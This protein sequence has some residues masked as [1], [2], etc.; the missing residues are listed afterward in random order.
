M[1][2]CYCLNQCCALCNNVTVT[3]GNK[4]WKTSKCSLGVCFLS[5]RWQLLS[6]VTVQ[7]TMLVLFRHVS[8][9]PFR[10]HERCSDFE[11]VHLTAWNFLQSAHGLM[12]SLLFEPPIRRAT[13]QNKE[14][15]CCFSPVFWCSTVNID[16]LFNNGWHIYEI[17]HRS[18]YAWKLGRK[19]NAV[20]KETVVCVWR[21]YVFVKIGANLKNIFMV[22]TPPRI[23][24]HYV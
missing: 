8:D 20:Q 7:V 4:Q 24:R 23:E 17:G 16:T 10:F 13:S 18:E 15:D 19:E 3:K 22:K 1:T 11:T 21:L 14:L 2:S 9:N 5:R 6:Q 12:V